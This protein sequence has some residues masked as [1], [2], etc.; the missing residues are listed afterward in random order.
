MVR[1]KI[2]DNK[3]ERKVGD[4]LKKYIKSGSEVSIICSNITIYAY[5]EMVKELSQINNARFIL[6]EFNFTEHIKKTTRKYQIDNSYDILGSRFEI[7][8]KN[9]LKQSSIGKEFALWVAEKTQIKAFKKPDVAKASLI[10]V[11]NK[12]LQLSINGTVNFT[13]DGLGFTSSNRNDMN[14]LI[15]DDDSTKDILNIFDEIWDSHQVKD[16][17]ADIL[18]KLQKIYIENTAE[19][20]Y[21]TTLYNVFNNDIETLNEEESIKKN[22]GF[23]NSI[24]WNKLYTFQKDGAIGAIS[25]LEKYNGCII[26]DSVG[27]GKT[28][29][30]LAV[31]KYYELRNYKVLVLTPKKLKENWTI[32]TMNDRKNLLIEDRFNY[33]VLNHTDLSRYS[34]LSG[35]INLETINWCNYDLIV[36]DESHNFRNNSSGKNRETRY[37]RLLNEVIKKGVKSKILMLSATPVNN[38][39]NDIKNQI[40]FITEGNDK[41]FE[42]DGIA[43]ISQ[44]LK[45]AQTIFNKWHKTVENEKTPDTFIEMINIDYFKLLETV[46]IARSRKHV[47]KYYNIEEVGKFPIRNKPKNIYSNIDLKKEF[48]PLKDINKL[49]KNLKLG[50]YSPINYVLH[51]KRD[52]YSKLYD[53]SI[54][55]GKSIFRQVDRE[56]SIVNLMRINFLKRLESSIHSFGITVE[57]TLNKIEN[58]IKI[59]DANKLKSNIE[60]DIEN[61]EINDPRAEEYL[62]GSKVKVLL[63]DMDLIKWREDL[64]DDRAKLKEIIEETRKVTKD[65]DEKLNRLKNEIDIKIKNPLNENNQKVII[66]TA[67][68]DTAKYLY[69]N[70]SEWAESNYGI[71]SAL[72]TGSGNNKTT[73]EIKG[74]SDLNTLLTNFSPLSKERAKIDGNSSNNI[75]ILIATDCISEG[76]NLQDC[77]Y[78]INYDI[79]WNPVRIIQRFGRIDRIGSKNKTIQ[80]V[81]FWPNMEL[82]EYIDLKNKVTGKMVLLDISATGEENIIEENVKSGMND[83]DYR[84]KQLKQLKEEIFDLED[85]AG[86]ISITDLTIND[87]KIDLTRYMAKYKDKLNS[88]PYGIYALSTSDDDEIKPGVIFTL[89]QVERRNNLK[90][91]NALY[92]YYMAYVYDDGTVKFNYLNIKKIL[93]VY[94]KLCLGKNEVNNELVKKFNLETRNGKDMSKYSSLLEK[95]IKNIIGKNS[96]KGSVSLFSKGGT[97]TKNSLLLEVDDFE[98]ISFLI[99][100]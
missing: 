65:R 4:E 51:D 46:T 97:V 61:M 25:K 52:K 40:T 91:N 18:K 76:Q 100:K 43:S 63:Q 62:I 42:E 86:G 29:T 31:I 32:H 72:I 90:N 35:E 81:N 92:P 28:F 13:S 58:V 22:I 8:M 96:E 12:D 59:I 83:F 84:K 94:K 64:E 33:D 36:I 19:Y 68:A 56:K 50:L 44:T 20:I 82:D 77:D 79:H 23:K 2:L 6:S 85:I 87:F 93:D 70:I 54:K 37:S 1:I 34:G 73:L 30:A 48:P 55:N 16:I 9:E 60:V 98:L 3:M 80:L 7:R 26:A 67:F 14:I 95:A 45:K 89:K 47:E 17:K 49:I 38:K 15:V 71:C 41:A 53:T 69:E 74:K 78:L 10:H 75:D 57:K 66:F 24:I 27:L 99:I 39:M 11:K 88:A 5:K 21:F